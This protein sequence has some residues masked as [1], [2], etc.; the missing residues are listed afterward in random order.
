[1]SVI[2]LSL[3]GCATAYQSQGFTGGFS[4]TQLSDNMFKVYFKGNGY[5]GEERVEDF[6]L[7]RS[8]EIA[9]EHGFPFFAVV[10][11]HADASYSTFTMPSQT[12]T[13]VNVTTFGNVAYGS[14]H[15]TTYGGGSELIRKPSDRNTIVCFKDKSLVRGQVYESLFVIQSMRAK[16]GLPQDPNKPAWHPEATAES[17]KLRCLAARNLCADGSKNCRSYQTD[18]N[19]DGIACPGVNRPPFPNMK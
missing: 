19:A 3:G 4:E 5:T 11:E 7:L 10:D 12:Y 18:F 2:I 8:A 1:M 16:Y 13:N 14:A 15:S 6:T 17:T 9:E